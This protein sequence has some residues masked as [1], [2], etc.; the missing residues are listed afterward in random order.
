MPPI[1]MG[2]PMLINISEF[3]FQF[4]VALSTGEMDGGFKG[5]LD[6]LD[7]SMY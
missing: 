2:E 5:G 1:Q 3:L 7:V 4:S 6:I